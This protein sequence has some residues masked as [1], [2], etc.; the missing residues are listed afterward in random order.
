M[1]LLPSPVDFLNAI[2][3][4]DAPYARQGMRYG[5]GPRH[6]LDVYPAAASGP[7][8]VIVFFYGGGWEGGDRGN[9]FL[10]D[11]RWHRAASRPSFPITEFTRRCASPDSS[12]TR[13]L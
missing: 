13:R 4:I 12:R 7:S 9:Y 10:W 2:A 5:S 3:R 11:R 8:P 1:N 6:V